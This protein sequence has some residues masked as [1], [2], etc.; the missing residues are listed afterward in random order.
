MTTSTFEVDGVVLDLDGVCVDVSESYR[1]AIKES[2]EIVYGYSVGDD[3]IQ[4]LKDLGGFNNDWKVTYACALY[5][6]AGSEEPSLTRSDWISTVEQKGRGLQAARKAVE[7]IFE[8]D[9]TRRIMERW[10]KKKLRAVFQ[11]LYLGSEDYARMEDETSVLVR[12]G[13]IHD[14]PILL[15]NRTREFLENYA[16][17]GILTG[18]PRQEALIALRRM[19]WDL[20]S[21]RLV[22]MEDWRKEKPAPDALVD[23]AGDFM[24]DEVVYAGDTLDDIRTAQNARDI[25][26]G[27]EY[28]GVGV[29]T[30]GLTGEEGRERYWEAGADAVVESVNELPMLLEESTP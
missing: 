3:L 30:G 6:L 21:D 15:E 2:V 29:L 20:D 13:Y 27:R 7:E 16:D 1:R 10:N 28:Y 5:V 23:L 8:P 24:A 25:D 26:D 4:S 17:V 11:E 14:E 18:R 9:R 12:S 22:A 19:D